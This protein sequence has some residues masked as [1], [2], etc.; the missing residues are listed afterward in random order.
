MIIQTDDVDLTEEYL[1]D[2]FG[3]LRRHSARSAPAFSLRLFGAP[4]LFLVRP[5]ATSFVLEGQ[6]ELFS[7]RGAA[8]GTGKALFGDAFLFLDGM[9]HRQRRQATLAQFRVGDDVIDS[10]VAAVCSGFVEWTRRE[11]VCAF[12]SA[13]ELFLRINCRILFGWDPGADSRLLVSLT[14]ALASGLFAKNEVDDVRFKVAVQAKADLREYWR[15]NLSSIRFAAESDYLGEIADESVESLY[16]HLNMM[17][18]VAFETCASTF[19]FALNELASDVDVFREC[20][21]AAR[22]CSIMGTSRRSSL[23]LVVLETLR[24]WPPA[25][26]LAREATSKV[27]FGGYQ[28]DPGTIVCVAPILLHRMPELYSRPDEFVPSR[29][30]ASTTGGS[31]AGGYVPFGAG[32]K[33]CVAR[34]LAVRETSAV[35][36]R[37]LLEWDV[38]I[39]GKVLALDWVP[40][41]RPAAGPWIS[42]RARSS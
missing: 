17:L 30:S 4:H 13:Q 38:D 2:V 14:E 33:V 31:P 34:R 28:I 40:G 35:L 7:A 16:H 9:L 23:E 41:L 10:T 5:E 20:V 8:L 6:A 15:S 27:E 19:A 25:Y 36:S 12:R 42:V 3:T 1:G 21:R 39:V 22:S 11:A 18:W 24:L 32:A 37:L 29:F 26:V